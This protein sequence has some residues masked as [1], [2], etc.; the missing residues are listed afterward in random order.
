M[1][2]LALGRPTV[3]TLGF[4][5]EPF[6]EKSG[7]AL[8]AAPDDTAALVR[9]TE[10]L[11]TKPDARVRIGA[12]AAHLYRDRFDISRVIEALRGS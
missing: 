1:A 12:A 11:L 9:A 7:V 5:S 10:Q 6:W 4:L 2:G 3:T 8:F